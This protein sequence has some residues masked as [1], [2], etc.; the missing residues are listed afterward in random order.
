MIIIIT[1]I[2]RRRSKKKE[3]KLLK[4]ESKTCIREKQKFVLELNVTDAKNTERK[5]KKVNEKTMEGKQS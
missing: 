5:I 1:I 4:K 2:P 3:R